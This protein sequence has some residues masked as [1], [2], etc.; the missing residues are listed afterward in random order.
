MSKAENLIVLKK[1]GV[2]VP[3]FYVLENSKYDKKSFNNWFQ[4]F[5][6][7]TM[8]AV[9]SS[10]NVEDG[11]KLSYAG[12][13]DTYLYVHKDKI[14]EFIDKCFNSI[15]NERVSDYMKKNG[16]KEKL[17]LKVIIQKMIDSEVSGVLFSKNPLTQ[18]KEFYIE[19]GYGIG[20]GVVSGE[21]TPDIIRADFKTTKIIDY[22][23]G[24]QVYKYGATSFSSGMEKKLVLELNQSKKKLDPKKIKT[25]LHTVRKI[26]KIF[27]YNLDVEFGVFKNKVYILQVRP[28]TT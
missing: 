1:N 3:P 5:D 10:C 15:Y 20:E 22:K 4:K 16:I 24:F 25:L 27:P 28:M 7:S 21:V 6:S 18:E 8:F 11:K 14:N 9:R 12:L 19:C 13:F 26:N 23:P 2:N 17:V